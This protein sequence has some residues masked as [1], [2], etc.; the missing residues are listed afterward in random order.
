MRRI[1]QRHRETLAKKLE[2]SDEVAEELRQRG[3]F[4]VKRARV[5]SAVTL[6]RVPGIGSSGARRI[7][8][9]G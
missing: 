5:A 3:L 6:E 2:V 8:G 9:E 7:R 4:T 1:E